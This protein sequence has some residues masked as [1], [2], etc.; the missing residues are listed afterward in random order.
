[1][2]I[3]V[4][5]NFHFWIKELKDIALKIKIWKYIN[6]NEIIKKSKK[7]IYSD[8]FSFDVSNIAYQD[9]TF[10]FAFTSTSVNLLT[11]RNVTTQTFQIQISSSFQ[12][13]SSKIRQTIFFHELNINQQESYK[14]MIEKYRR[15]KKQISK[16]IQKMI[17]IDE[18]IKTF[19]KMYIFSKMM[20]FF[21]KEILQ[22]LIVKYE[23]NHTQ[24]DEQI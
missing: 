13:A 5:N 21:I 6:S 17:K 23:D 4:S 7:D 9:Q 22:L 10:A 8:V 19:T 14:T 11:S 3:L 12:S 20:S 18:I 16:I 1:M 24:D 15:R 2:L